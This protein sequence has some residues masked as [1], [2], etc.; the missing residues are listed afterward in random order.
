M[1]SLLRATFIVALL[2]LMRGVDAFGVMALSGNG[3]IDFNGTGTITHMQVPFIVHDV[4]DTNCTPSSNDVS[5]VRC[6]QPLD[7]SL[8]G[9]DIVRAEHFRVRVNS[10]TGFFQV[11]FGCSTCG[12]SIP[13]RLDQLVFLGSGVARLSDE[14]AAALQTLIDQH[15]ASAIHMSVAINGPLEIF[16]SVR[17]VTTDIKPDSSPNTLNLRSRG[18]I[19][20]ALLTTRLFD[21]TT[22]DVASLRFGATG[23]EVP[24]LRAVQED[25][26]GD[27]DIDLVVFFR[28]QN[29]DIDCETL[30][31]YISGATFSGDSIAGTDSV[32]I[33]ACH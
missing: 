32:T 25:V 28:S 24:A 26:D 33:V 23:Q 17:A 7:T 21:A 3:G 30:F 8:L 2:I 4:Y 11:R 27:G 6:N 15:G 29:T 10:N 13:L 22:I 18:V 31:T 19:P 20:I 14:Q 1:K 16:S 12:T 9:N 5:I